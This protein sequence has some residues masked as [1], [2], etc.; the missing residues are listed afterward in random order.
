MRQSVQPEVSRDD[1]H[2]PLQGA[3]GD[4]ESDPAVVADGIT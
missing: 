4:V 1:Y 3:K 2:D